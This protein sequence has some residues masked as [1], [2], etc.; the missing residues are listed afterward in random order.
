MSRFIDISPSNHL[1]DSI[2]ALGLTQFE[3]VPVTVTVGSVFW[4]TDGRQIAAINIATF[5]ASRGRQEPFMN[6]LN[7]KF[8]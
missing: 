7:S 8:C 3:Q 4:A 5:F 1:P 2:S 6:L